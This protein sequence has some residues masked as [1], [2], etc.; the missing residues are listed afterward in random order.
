MGRVSR[1]NREIDLEREELEHSKLPYLEVDR[2]LPVPICRATFEAMAEAG[3]PAIARIIFL[4]IFTRA[5]GRKAGDKTWGHPASDS[6]IAW[7]A[8][9]SRGTVRRMVPLLEERRWI[10][11]RYRHPGQAPVYFLGESCP[12][13]KTIK[14]PVP[15]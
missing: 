15:Q 14:E 7:A 3:L 13:P 6:E 1:T 2:L 10:E 11:R 8:G 9:C 5:Y 12:Q 4:F